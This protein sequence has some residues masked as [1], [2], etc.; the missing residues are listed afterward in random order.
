MRIEHAG[1]GVLKPGVHDICRWDCHLVVEVHPSDAS[2]RQI[3]WGEQQN[4]CLIHFDVEPAGV[5]YNQQQDAGDAGD[6]QG[7]QNGLRS[8][9]Q[10]TSHRGYHIASSDALL[11]AR[12]HT[13][14]KTR[15]IKLRKQNRATQNKL[16]NSNSP[17]DSFL[18]N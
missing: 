18:I 12:V 7:C 14:Q 15:R 3:G 13:S 17:F 5:E 2:H 10:R 16:T 9:S 4:G 6:H 1:D 11:R 8:L